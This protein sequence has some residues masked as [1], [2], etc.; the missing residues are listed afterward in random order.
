MLMLMLF[1]SC[2]VL[3]SSCTKAMLFLS[4]ICYIFI[5]FYFIFYLFI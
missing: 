2:I 3:T 5:L 1:I 4:Q